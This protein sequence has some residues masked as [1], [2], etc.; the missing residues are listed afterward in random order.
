MLQNI[1]AVIF[2][3]DGTLVDSMW[4]WEKIDVDYL[5]KMGFEL[6]K[7]FHEDIEGMSFSETAKYVKKRFNIKEDVETIMNIWHNMVVEYYE[8]AIQLKDGALEFIEYLYDK[9]IKMGIGSSNSRELINVIVGKY[10]LNK[11]IEHITT[12]CEVNKGKPSPDVYLKSAQKLGV[13]NDKCLVFEDIPNGIRA[14]KN[15]GM[16]CC[17]IYDDFSKD[18]TKLKKEISDYYIEDYNQLMKIL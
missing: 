1:E 12:S 13:K 3:L 2:D 17:A 15:A 7:D 8:N 5:A 6:P 9:G 18:A 11:Y 16:T 4:V 10:G 14:A